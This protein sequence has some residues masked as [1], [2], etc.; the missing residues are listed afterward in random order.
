MKKII[1]VLLCVITIFALSGCA[2]EYTLR[3]KCEVTLCVK[4]RA[5]KTYDVIDVENKAYQARYEAVYYLEGNKFR[6]I[7]EEEYPDAD[8]EI[9]AEADGESDEVKIYFY[10]ADKDTLREL[11]DE[12]TELFLKNFCSVK[13]RTKITVA[14]SATQTQ[15]IN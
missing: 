12:I 5:I 9:Y 6:Q 11:A 10:S 3:Y 15:K 7:V 8:Y 13:Y 14:E 4:Y 2:V 1:S